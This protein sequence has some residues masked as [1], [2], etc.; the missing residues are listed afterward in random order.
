MHRLD[1][2]TSGCLLFARSP[3]SRA[4]IQKAFESRAVEKHYLA[5]VAGEISDETGVIEMPIAKRSSAQA[6]WKMVCDPDGLEATTRWRRLAAHDGA[7]LVE[8]V[9]LTGRTH[10]IRVHAR[11]AFGS[12]I[13]GDQVYGIGRGPMLLHASRII[14]PRDRMSNIDV[15]A[16]LPSYFG[17]WCNAI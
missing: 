15:T 4:R 8:F 13:V 5:I 16:P 12:G 14:V 17:D 3:K 11:A 10:Q 6:G 7:T 2:D 1:M 9:P